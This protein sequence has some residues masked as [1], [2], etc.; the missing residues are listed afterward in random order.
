MSKLIKHIWRTALILLI[1][2][3]Y[4][5]FQ[6]CR[7]RTAPRP[8]SLAVESGK[9]LARP[10]PQETFPTPM[11]EPRKILKAWYL[12]SLQVDLVSNLKYLFLNQWRLKSVAKKLG[13]CHKL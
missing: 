6:F 1:E 4:F 3:H 11:E 12:G 10:E 13:L 7:D 5:Y 2:E 9:K 8:T